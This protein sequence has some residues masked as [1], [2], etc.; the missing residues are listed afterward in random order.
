M[1][2]FPQSKALLTGGNAK[3]SEPRGSL[4]DI[5]FALKSLVQADKTGVWQED[6]KKAW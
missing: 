3:I 1:G 6:S 4:T 2:M 5:Q